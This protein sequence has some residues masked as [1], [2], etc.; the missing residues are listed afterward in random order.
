MKALVLAE[1]KDGKCKKSSLEVVHSLSTQGCE[2]EVVIL[3]ANAE[4]NAAEI[5][6]EVGGQGA[7]KLI[8]I[9]DESF[10]YYQ[11]EGFAASISETF[12]SGGYKILAGAASSLVKDLFPTLAVRLGGGLAVDCVAVEVKG[13]ELKVKR[14]MLAGKYFALLKFKSTPAIFSVRPNV[15]GIGEAKGAAATVAAGTPATLV[16]KAKTASIA[17]NTSSARPDLTEADKI[18]S[19]GRAMKAAENYKIL[20]AL[21]DTIG[22]A[23]GASRAAVD[24]GMAPHSMQV[25]QTGKTVN[26]SLYIACGISGAIQHLAGMKTSKV[27]VAVNTDPEAPIFQRADYGAVGDLFQV[28]P[29][30]TAE[31]KKLLSQG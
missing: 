28:V 22:A 15:L 10:K 29:A 26:P 24:A 31:F 16:A 11:S 30:M 23:V 9:S 18:I 21:A 12:K 20:E 4:A 17:G 7:K 3:G 5:A 2:V 6:K 13:E 14:P 25:G 1:I 27:I 8:T 19:G